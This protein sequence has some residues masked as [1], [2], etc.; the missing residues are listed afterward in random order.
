MT[1]IIVLGFLLLLFALPSYAQADDDMN[2]KT[3]EELREYI[4]QLQ[5]ENVQIPQ[6]S[7][8]TIRTDP[9]LSQQLNLLQS[10]LADLKD[11]FNKMQERF[12]RLATDTDEAIL[13]GADTII[14]G[15]ET[16]TQKQIT[17]STNHLEEYIDQKTNPIRQNA[18]AIGAFLILA[19]C[20]LLWASRQYKL[21]QGG[22]D[23][24]SGKET[25]H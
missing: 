18:P 13:R 14:K 8:V 3:P 22:R 15:V 12:N 5:A 1:K 9:E 11:S 20:F 7:I 21:T 19:G 16:N 2:T 10:E 6:P 23:Y 17:D 24:G 25:K 4:Q